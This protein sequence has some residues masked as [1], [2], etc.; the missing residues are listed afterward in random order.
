M[1]EAFNSST[2]TLALEEGN[3]FISSIQEENNHGVG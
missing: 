3:L 1:P 2:N